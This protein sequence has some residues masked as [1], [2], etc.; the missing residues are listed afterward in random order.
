MENIYLA[1]QL[2]G[3]TVAPIDSCAITLYADTD[4]EL[5]YMHNLYI[6]TAEPDVLAQIGVIIG[7]PWP[8]APAGT[9]SGGMFTFSAAAS[10]PTVDATKGFGGVSV[11]TG[12]KLSTVNESGSVVMPIYNYRQLLKLVAQSKRT[13]FSIEALDHLINLFVATNY[14]ITWDANYDV[15]ITFHPIIDTGSLFIIQ[16]VIS[17]FMLMPQIILIQAP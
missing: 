7:L 4:I 6:D 3:S 2:S 10:F 9:F 11:Y 15:N 13:G 14:T 5:S 12:G 8:A 1:K 17:L 16:Q